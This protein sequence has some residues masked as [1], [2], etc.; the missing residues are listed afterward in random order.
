MV[1]ALALPV[2]LGA[3]SS[4]DLVVPDCRDEIEA[5]A[6]E[7]RGDLSGVSF[8]K[9]DLSALASPSNAVLG[10]SNRIPEAGRL[11]VDDEEE[12]GRIVIALG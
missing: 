2:L 10:L 8:K 1:D 6:I 12:D 3:G 4:R 7:V 11:I 5:P 9:I